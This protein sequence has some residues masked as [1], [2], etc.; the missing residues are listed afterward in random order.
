M[1]SVMTEISVFSWGVK[2]WHSNQM[3]H[4]RQRNRL[5]E[6]YTHESDD[7]WCFALL[8][9]L[10][11]GFQYNRNDMRLICDVETTT[12]NSALPHS[13]SFCR[14]HYADSLDSLSLKSIHLQNCQRKKGRN[15][16]MEKMPFWLNFEFIF[17]HD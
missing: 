7:F 8:G 3:I 4:F 13:T 6:R 17:L 15:E 2:R 16:I 11:N 9:Q 5:Q 14:S 10:R 12:N 1:L